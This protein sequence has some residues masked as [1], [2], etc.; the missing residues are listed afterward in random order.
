MKEM[1]ILN[2]EVT[3]TKEDD[4]FVVECDGWEREYEIEDYTVTRIVDSLKKEFIECDKYNNYIENFKYLN[5]DLT[6]SIIEKILKEINSIFNK[7]FISIHE[8]ECEGCFSD[9]E[10]PDYLCPV[11]GFEFLIEE[12][13]IVDLDTDLDN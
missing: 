2:K 9:V 7:N 13:K 12:N 8:I 11:A 6:P 4:V 1:K 3:I 10:D 5:V